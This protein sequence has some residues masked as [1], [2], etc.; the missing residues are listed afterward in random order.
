MFD[1]YCDYDPAEFYDATIVMHARKQHKCDE[2]FKQIM[3]GH[4]Y[5][6]VVGKWEG[7]VEVYKTCDRCLSLR[8][9]VMAHV[10]C[11][12]WA[13]GNMIDDVIEAARDFSSEAPGL[14]FGA[15]R[16]KIKIDHVGA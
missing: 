9:W 15:Y 14:L 16:R 4:R 12:C 7:R 5:E 2:C 8:E 1:C 10:P 13:H 11:A 6:R 3:I